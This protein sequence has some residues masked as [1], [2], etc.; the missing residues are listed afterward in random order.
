MTPKPM[1][2]ETEALYRRVALALEAGGVTGL[3]DV[4]P[5][6]IENPTIEQVQDIINRGI[7]LTRVHSLDCECSGTGVVVPSEAECFLRLVNTVIAL[8]HTFITCLERLS[9]GDAYI[10]VCNL[11]RIGQ[12]QRPY[13]GDY[14]G[15]APAVLT[16]LL[17]A[18][19]ALEIE[20]Q[21]AT[22]DDSQ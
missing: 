22:K 12:H 10:K 11:T 9:D 3:M 19:A 5:V 17:W 14:I 16:A 2:L 21:E 20:A 6:L 18:T 8:P 15:Q 7:W 4:C 1:T 13:D